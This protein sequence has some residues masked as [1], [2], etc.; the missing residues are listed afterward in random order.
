MLRMTEECKSVGP[1]VLIII[2]QFAESRACK[3]LFER[4][5]GKHTTAQSKLINGCWN[6]ASKAVVFVVVVVLFCFLFFVFSD[7]VSLC[8]PRCPGTHSVDQAGIELR[9]VTASA[10]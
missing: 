8:N 3:L 1:T 6:G 9:N 10:T 7:R 5:K 4:T 2:P